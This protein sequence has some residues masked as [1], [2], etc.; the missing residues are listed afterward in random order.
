MVE[1]SEVATCQRRASYSYADDVISFDALWA[2]A[3]KCCL[4][5]NWKP[6]VKQFM[7]NL[8][9]EIL[10][11]STALALGAWVNGRPQEILILYPKKRQGL[12]IKFPD[13][14]YQ[15]S[16]NDNVLYPEM[17][18]HF[19]AGNC[20]CQKGKGPD[21]ARM[22]LKKYLWNFY[23][24]YGLDGYILQIDI[25][26]YYPNMRHDKVKECFREY[27][28]WDVEQHIEEVLDQQ[29]VGDVGYNPG[30]QMVQ[31]AGI[32]LLNHLDH[33]I[34]E[35]LRRRYYLR[36]MD[37]FTIIG[38]TAEELQVVLDDIKIRLADLGFSVSEKKTHIQPLSER[39]RFLGF[40]YKMTDTGKIIMTVNPESVKHERKKIFRLNM[41]AAQGEITYDKVDE[42]LNSYVAHLEHGNSD[43]LIVRLREYNKSIRQEAQRIYA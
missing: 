29:Y 26:G 24:N 5:V 10:R 25:S 32:S 19:I 3:V 31:I 14:V 7:N 11:M 15:R 35:D 12:S 1:P 41:L 17:V 16:I 39:F 18:R 38:R 22:L 33:H 36:Y 34:K 27:I 28:P 42:C 37:D 6:S 20:A 13:R 8:A 30:S 9:F 21:Y 40:D 43:N 2:S 4:G 23:A